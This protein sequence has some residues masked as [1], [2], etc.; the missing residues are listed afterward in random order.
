[1]PCQSVHDTL[2]SRSGQ[3]MLRILLPKNIMN[4]FL[5]P[6]TALW[7]NK[8]RNSCEGC[9]SSWRDWSSS[10]PP[11]Q[12]RVLPYLDTSTIAGSPYHALLHGF[13]VAYNASPR[14]RDARLFNRL[15]ELPIRIVFRSQHL[16]TKRIRFHQQAPPL[17]C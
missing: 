6:R 13:E 2:L 15:Q 17:S 16:C 5:V 7:I 10:N 1:V 12:P 8:V 3:Y 9:S 14:V 11:W 4:Q